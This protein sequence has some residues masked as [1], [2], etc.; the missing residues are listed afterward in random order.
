[1]IDYN[2]YAKL[3]LSKCVNLQPQEDLLINA[4]IEAIDFVDAL[5]LAA[6]KDF[7]SGTVHINWQAPTLSK[8]KINYGS[9]KVLGDVP[10]YV[11]SRYDTMIKRNA[12]VINLTSNMASA[13]KD[14]D[15]RKMKQASELSAPKV[16]PFD[17]KMFQELK[18]SLIP[19]PSMAWA[20]RTYPKL[21]ET[22]AAEKLKEAF[23]Y[24]MHLDE[25]NPAKAW[26][27]QLETIEKRRDLLN[28]K[29]YKMLRF[30][31]KHTQLDLPL[32]EN[33]TWTGGREYHAN[34]SFVRQLPDYKISTA[35]HKFG[36]SGT[37]RFTTPLN[38]RGQFLKPFTLQFEDGKIIQIL[39]D[40]KNVVEKLFGVDEGASYVGK[41]T[42]IGDESPIKHLKTFF[43]MGLIDLNFGSS[44]ALGHA[45]P[46]MLQGGTKLNR[47]GLEEAGLNQSRIHVEGIFAS[48]DMKVYGVLEDDEEELIMEKNAFVGAFV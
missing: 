28:Q 8:Y 21:S 43:Y 2:V 40:Q 5:V 1:M 42:L 33:H 26:E 13:M 6:Y 7:K 3:V 16:R 11:L 35:P 12:A 46:R 29:A 27:V 22:E 36:A 4:P 45:D 10:N 32:A 18:W 14:I 20:K 48:P 19:F 38:V 31:S 47:T 44:I 30:R 17:Q 9:E 23:D 24:M 25:K 39:S 41:V 37:V 15:P 34:G